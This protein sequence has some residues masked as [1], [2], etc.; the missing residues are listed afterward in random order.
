[1]AI[2]SIFRGQVSGKFMIDL[3]FLSERSL[4][5]KEEVFGIWYLVKPGRVIHLARRPK[6]GYLKKKTLSVVFNSTHCTLITHDN[7]SRVMFS[8]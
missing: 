1:M 7:D 6:A 4:K 3:G 8:T 5:K 2:I